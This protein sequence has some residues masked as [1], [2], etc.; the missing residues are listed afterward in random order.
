MRGRAEQKEFYERCETVWARL[1]NDDRED[2]L[3]LLKT[4]KQSEPETMVILDRF[5]R[6]RKL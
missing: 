3:E 5:I 1:P 6:S 4:I 2:F